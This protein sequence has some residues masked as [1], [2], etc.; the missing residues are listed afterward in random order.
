MS[1][2]LFSFVVVVAVCRFLDK[3]EGMWDSWNSGLDLP[4]ERCEQMRRTLFNQVLTDL[5]KM[6]RT[7][8][9]RLKSKV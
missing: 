9:L 4:E 3:E 1:G 2:F 8:D 7:F 5:L 6:I